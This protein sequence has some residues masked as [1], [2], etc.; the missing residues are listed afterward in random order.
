[1]ERPGTDPCLLAHAAPD[2]PTVHCWRNGEDE[3]LSDSSRLCS[4]QAY[5]RFG[6]RIDG[7]TSGRKHRGAGSWLDLLENHDGARHEHS[8]P[9][10]VARGELANAPAA[11]GTESEL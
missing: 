6:G 7:K 9:L 11:Q 2:D 3:A 1:M 4:W 10:C 5:F 8:A